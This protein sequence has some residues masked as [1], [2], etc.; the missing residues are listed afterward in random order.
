MLARRR[1]VAG[2]ERKRRPPADLS[3][4][5]ADDAAHAASRWIET[6][7]DHPELGVTRIA[8]RSRAKVNV[9]ELVA[10]LR[11]VSTDASNGPLAVTAN[12]VM[13]GEDPD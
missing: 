2:P 3:A 7:E 11:G 4:R 10:H 5:H 8:L 9:T 6:R 1:Q 12:H 13:R